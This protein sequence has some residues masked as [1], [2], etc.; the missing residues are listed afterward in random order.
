MIDDIKI[1]ITFLLLII[2]YVVNHIFNPLYF[3]LRKIKLFNEVFFG[4]KHIVTLRITT[5]IM[6]MLRKY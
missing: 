2:I 5:L 1:V 3:I 6:K 4:E